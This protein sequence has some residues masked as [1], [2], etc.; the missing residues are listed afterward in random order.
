MQKEYFTFKN[1]FYTRNC[2]LNNSLKRSWIKTAHQCCRVGKLVTNWRVAR[3]NYSKFN[4]SNKQAKVIE[5]LFEKKSYTKCL[6]TCFHKKNLKRRTTSSV[7][8]RHRVQ[9]N[10]DGICKNS[11]G[12]TPTSALP[13]ETKD[14]DV[15]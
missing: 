6:Y 5:K 8:G 3:F 9:V 12:S 13:T 1:L 7:T 15:G 11:C 4:F 2:I 10:S 14:V